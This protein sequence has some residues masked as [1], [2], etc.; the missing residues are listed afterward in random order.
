MVVTVTGSGNKKKGQ[1][2][3][4]IKD[5]CGNPVA[6]ATVSGTFSGSINQSLSAVTNA[7]GVATL[8]TSNTAGGTVSV[9]FC[10]TKQIS[11]LLI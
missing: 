8:I 9:T 10:M 3:V 4:T 5:N 7:S 2:T 6:N 11:W 1:A